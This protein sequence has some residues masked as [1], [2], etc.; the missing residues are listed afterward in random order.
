MEIII[1]LK[2]HLGGVNKPIVKKDDRVYRGQLIAVPQG[3]G[4][5]IHSSY[6]GKISSIDESSLHIKIDKEQ[7]EDYIKL[8]LSKDY[9]EIIKEAGIVGA[10]G[11]GFPTNIKLNTEL[12][13]GFVIINAAECE[14]MLEH[15]IER[16][17]K[18]PELII[19]GLVYA[20]EITKAKYGYIAIKEKN[21]KAIL[22]LEK[23]IED[24]E[25]IEIKFLED[26][27]PAGDERVIIK[28]ILGIKL[29]PGKL[30]LEANAVVLN[31]ETTKNIALAIEEG[32]PVITKDVTLDGRVQS[33]KKIL[34]DVPIGTSIKKLI[35]EAGGYIEPYGEVLLGGPFTGRPGSEDNQV[36][37][38]LGGILITMPLPEDTRKFGVIGCECGAD[39]P[40]L[41][42][43]VEK[44]GGEVIKSVNCKRMVD[45][46]GRLRCEEPGVCPGQ[47]EQVI[48][49]KKA[50][51]EVIIAG[52][53][54]P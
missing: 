1:P 8:D 3:L 18:N 50:G 54:E 27:Y 26:V 35:E 24:L 28:E 49:L 21:K 7:P 17:E 2:Q 43:I 11:A 13:D 39:I 31:T 38:T 9:L 51:A 4:A 45:V 33:G 16:I 6:S 20:M 5:N 52:T 53:C 15:N 40:R 48:Q 23:V 47:A 29:K 42:E 41:K 14:P 22:E 44:M 12:K 37:K 25:N 30:P 19:R 10:G 36:I 34:L 46:D 32:M